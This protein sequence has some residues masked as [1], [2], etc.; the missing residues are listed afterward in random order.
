MGFFVADTELAAASPSKR[1]GRGSTRGGGLGC[2]A[3]SLKA[4]WPSIISPRMKIVGPVD[5]DILILGGNITQ[6]D[7][8]KGKPWQDDAQGAE[9]MRKLIPRH[10]QDRIAYQSMVRCFP[11]R[12]TREDMDNVQACSI[13][14]AADI[15]SRPIKYV[16]GV[17]QLPSKFF[18]PGESLFDF[19]GTKMPIQ[20]GGK[21]L[22]FFPVFDPYYVF[23]NL[24]R[25]DDGPVAPIFNADVKRFFKECETWGK[26]EIVAP[27][28]ASVL[29]PKTMEEARNMLAQLDGIVGYDLETGREGH[30]EYSGV[31]KPM[32]RDARVLTAGFSDGKTTIA[33]PVQHPEMTHDWAEP[34][35]LETL[36]TRPWAAHNAGMELMWSIYMAH[37]HG[38]QP[39]FKPFDDSMAIAR[40]YHNRKYILNLGLVTRIHLGVNY[41]TLS[42]VNAKMILS[43]P[44]AEVLP[45]NGLDAQGTALIVR[46]ALDYVRGDNYDRMIA[47]VEATARME[48]M[49]LSVDLDASASLR[50]NWELQSEN[51]IKGL[52][53]IYE[54]KR[55]EETQGRKF[56]ISSPEDVGE[57]LAVHGKI[58]LTKTA[59]GK[60]YS[61]E[62]ALLTRL[63]P[64]NP[65]VKA[66]L[67]YREAEKICSTYIDPVEN[68]PVLYVD[69][70]LH[71]SYTVML[72]HTTRL[73]S[74]G[75]NIQNFP[76]RS[77]KEL[78]KQIIAPPGHSFYAFDYGQLEARCIAMATRDKNLIE[79]TIKGRDIHSDWLNNCLNIYPDYLTRLAHE[80]GQTEEKKIRKAG[81]DIIKTDFVFASFFGASANSVS[82]RTSIPRDLVDALHSTFWLEFRGVA[83]WI[84]RM[85]QQ[86]KDTGSS[87][88]L[89]G[90]ERHG[91]MMGNEPINNP[92]QGTGASIVVEAMNELSRLSVELDDPYLHPRVNIHD[93]LMFILPEDDTTHMYIEKIMEVMVKIRFT[94]QIVPLM[95][96]G[97]VGS[98]WADLEEFTTY[99]GDYIR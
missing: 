77:H 44:L 93:D 65:L 94:W 80:T 5:A 83:D 96:E 31:L 9:L 8:L 73:S 17:G 34:L 87:W 22:W 30:G 62:D 32:I 69:G 48:L 3:C 49:G 67:N 92:I 71:P 28:P 60:Q 82:T 81:R 88:L 36:R 64:D 45:Y 6:L 59:G 41:K 35:I 15:E 24:G 14:L 89:N 86:Y 1:P 63:A 66:V 85:R 51:A 68:V 90:I 42:K 25:F 27:D 29:V 40:L 95:V 10:M 97:R 2:D 20:I 13:H 4:V 79:S 16:L 46:Q 37:R 23:Q 33:F 57:A 47:S 72:T 54:V 21:T 50:K 70:L 18:V 43:Y 98:N 99:T 58:P 61:T 39:G 84:K 11:N 7:D 38:E 26:P 78:R 75:P 91:V 56:S 19:Y 53:Q 74:N 52:N 12:G 76:K 55:F